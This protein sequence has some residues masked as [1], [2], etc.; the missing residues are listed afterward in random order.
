MRECESCGTS[1]VYKNAQARY[2]STRCRVAAHR[3]TIPNV[4]T[5][6]N[7]WTR[8]NGKRPITTDGL[9]ASSTDPLTWNTYAQVKR[10][11]SGDGYGIMLGDGLGCYDLDHVTDD[12][13]RTIARDI[14]E[15][16]IYA[17]R[18]QSGNGVHIFVAAPESAGTR[19]WRDRHERYTRARFIRVTGNRISL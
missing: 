16:I 13:A 5:R 14:P 4:L 18:S 10:S 17:E 1:I 8:A 15:Q 3:A 2:C 9:P 19:K 11:K 6:R 12:E 7:T